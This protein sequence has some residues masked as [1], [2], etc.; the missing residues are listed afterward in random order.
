MSGKANVVSCIGLLT[1]S[2]NSP[3]RLDRTV[4]PL[5]FDS[6]PKLLTAA[7]KLTKEHGLEVPPTASELGRGKA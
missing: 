1:G 2:V 5:G 3:P 6:L 4:A 7:R